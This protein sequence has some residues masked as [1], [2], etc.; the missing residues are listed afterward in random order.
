MSQTRETE[1]TEEVK[2]AIGGVDQRRADSATEPAFF[3]F[4]SG[5]FPWKGDY[6]RIFGKRPMGRIVNGGGFAQA[7]ISIHSIPGDA[8]LYQT[9]MGLVREEL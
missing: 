4:V 3:Q 5:I 6:R 2:G 9:R 7:I 1:S 8:V